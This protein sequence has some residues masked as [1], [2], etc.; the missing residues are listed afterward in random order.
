MLI[1]GENGVYNNILFSSLSNASNYDESS[2][3]LLN[4]QTASR[5]S[6]EIC[7]HI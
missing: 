1:K 7:E 5:L 3:L 2:Y 4:K 6:A